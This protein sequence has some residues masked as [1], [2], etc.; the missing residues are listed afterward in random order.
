MNTVEKNGPPVPKTNGLDVPMAILPEAW[1]VPAV[2]RDATGSAPLSRIALPTH[3][4]KPDR[5]IQD[6]IAKLE[7][8]RQVGLLTALFGFW[9]PDGMFELIDGLTRYQALLMGGYK[10]AAIRDLGRVPEPAEILAMQVTCNEAV[11]KMSDPAIADALARHRQ[12]TQGTLASACKAL[13]I[14]PSRGTKIMAISIR[15]CPSVRAMVDAGKLKPRAA[16]AISKL[17]DSEQQIQVATKAVELPMAVETVEEIV[18]GMLSGK[19]PK[20]GKPMKLRGNGVEMLLKNPTIEGVIA[21]AEGVLS[22]AKKLLK[23]GDGIE[24]LPSR[25]KAI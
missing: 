10:E 20:K 8:I 17:S 5:S 11:A 3:D 13:G 14:K 25:L 2:P 9:R 15:L 12:L 18:D 22:A 6:V 1:T 16:Y 24:F 7:S 21:F 4:V 23:D 19:K